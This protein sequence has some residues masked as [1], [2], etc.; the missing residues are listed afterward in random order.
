MVRETSAWH[1]IFQL[2]WTFIQSSFSLC[3]REG[4]KVRD[5]EMRCVAV[6]LYWMLEKQDSIF[7]TLCISTAPSVDQSDSREGRWVLLFEQW[8]TVCA[9]EELQHSCWDE[10]CFL[11][12]VSTWHVCQSLKS[13]SIFCK[14]GGFICDSSITQPVV[15][16]LITTW[17]DTM[18]VLEEVWK[19]RSFSVFSKHS[20]MFR[21]LE[22]ARF[23]PVVNCKG[24]VY[25]C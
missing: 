13:N 21:F 8:A 19:V 24:L 11:V 9:D 12:P 16:H 14:I 10:F 20:K 3:W 23:T 5:T 15:R 25:M 2:T 6:P 4:K 22:K 1:R 7:V 17:E 18:L